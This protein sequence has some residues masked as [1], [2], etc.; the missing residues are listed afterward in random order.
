MKSRLTKFLALLMAAAVVFSLA[1]CGK[2]TTTTTTAAGET[3]TAAGETTTAAGET[4]TA[5]GETTTA[6]GETTTAAVTTAAGETTT[7]GEVTTIPVNVTMPK[8]N[9]QILAAYTAVMNKA[10]TDKPAFKKYEYQELPDGAQYRNISGG[11]AVIDPLLSL[12]NS[13]FLTTESKAQANP[14]VYAKGGD[15]NA[16]PVKNATKG[17]LLTDVSAIKSASCVKLSDG[18]YKLTITLNN[19]QNPAHYRTGSTA[20]SKTGSIFVPLDKGDVDP[21]LSSGIVKAVVS[22]AQ[23]SM[24][25]YNCMVTLVYN[26]INQRV[27]SVDQ[28]LYNKL[29]MS[30]TVLLFLKASGWTVLIMHYNIFDVAY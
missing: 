8:T 18:N 2:N 22:K 27:I 5:A 14:G 20:P 26:P 19:E 15:M 4:T 16:F 25:Y 3:T 24:E 9:A 28:I 30:G 23:Y 1:G 6:A 13:N 12:V 7:A 29:T 17:C 21:Q 11:S 10:K